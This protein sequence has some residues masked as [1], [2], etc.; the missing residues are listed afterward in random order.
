MMVS[1]SKFGVIVERV[2]KRI[3]VRFLHTTA[4]GARVLLATNHLSADGRCK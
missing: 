2:V 4:E 1:F 3:G